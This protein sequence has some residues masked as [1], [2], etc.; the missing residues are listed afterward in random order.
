[1]RIYVLLALVLVA[2]AQ[3]CVQ[4]EINVYHSKGGRPHQDIGRVTS[5]DQ[6]GNLT[7]E[8]PVSLVPK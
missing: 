1:M 7:A 6:N 3:G 4:A 5:S 8:V 2:L